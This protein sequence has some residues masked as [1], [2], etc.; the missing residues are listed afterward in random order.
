M[1]YGATINCTWSRR[2]RMLLRVRGTDVGVCCSAY[3]VLTWV[4][5]AARTWCVCCYAYVV[6]MWAYAATRAWY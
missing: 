1:R 2:G 5:A 3:V 6:L 4:Y